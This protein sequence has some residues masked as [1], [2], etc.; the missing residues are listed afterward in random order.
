MIIITNWFICRYILLVVKIWIPGN[1]DYFVTVGRASFGSVHGLAS[2]VKATIKG[3]DIP[4]VLE[5]PFWS[6][7]RIK[8]Q[9]WF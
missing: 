6:A 5:L 9:F 3:H 7:S 4:D 2:N 8:Q 1:V